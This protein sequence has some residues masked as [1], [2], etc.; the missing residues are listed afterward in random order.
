MTAVV[1]ISKLQTKN[2][3]DRELLLGLL[4]DMAQYCRTKESRI[5]RYIACLPVDDSDSNGTSVY[6]VEE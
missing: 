6:T 5:R 3:D 1:T 4:G 2:N